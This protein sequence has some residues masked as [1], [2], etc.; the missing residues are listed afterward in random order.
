MFPS[1]LND[2]LSHLCPS[3]PSRQ[4]DGGPA[5]KLNKASDQK[6]NGARWEL[7]LYADMTLAFLRH[8]LFDSRVYLF[9]HVR[10]CAYAQ[11]ACEQAKKAYVA[12]VSF[13]PRPLVL[14]ALWAQVITIQAT[15]REV[16]AISFFF[17]CPPLSFLITSPHSLF[18]LI[19]WRKSAL[20]S[21]H[22]MCAAPYCVPIFLRR[23]AR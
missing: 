16:A 15:H 2:T 7:V 14:L 1:K 5:Q 8:S 11:I 12:F 23:S 22:G 10:A 4:R 6:V 17:F 19:S 3:G 20:I 13:C 21:P 18:F 9:A